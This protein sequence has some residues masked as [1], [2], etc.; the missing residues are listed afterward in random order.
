[1]ERVRLAL[2]VRLL[3]YEHL[4]GNMTAE[5]VEGKDMR[6]KKERQNYMRENRTEE[7]EAIGLGGQACFGKKMT[8]LTIFPYL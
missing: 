5:I 8:K 6:G 7:S 2:M 3:L 4:S 1:M